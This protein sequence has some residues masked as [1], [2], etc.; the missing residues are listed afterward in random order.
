MESSNDIL[1]IVLVA[2]QLEVEVCLH[3]FTLVLDDPIIFILFV[4]VAVLALVELL[5]QTLFTCLELTHILLQSIDL[6]FLNFDGILQ[7]SD[8]LVLLSILFVKASDTLLQLLQFQVV[9]LTLLFEFVGGSSFRSVMVI[10]EFAHFQCEFLVA[11]LE[12]PN[13]LVAAPLQLIQIVALAGQNRFDQVQLTLQILNLTVQ[14]FLNISDFL[15]LDL[16]G[17]VLGFKF[18]LELCSILLEVDVPSFQLG[19]E[20]S[21]L[22]FQRQSNLVLL[23]DEVLQFDVLGIHHSFQLRNF[24]AEDLNLIGVGV[25]YQPYFRFAHA[26]KLVSQVGQLKFKYALVVSNLVLQS[27]IFTLHYQQRL[28]V[29]LFYL[30]IFVENLFD[31]LVLASDD[32]LEL[33]IFVVKALHFV[34]VLLL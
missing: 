24:M 5:S 31:F 13:L 6:S 14:Q 19:F 10:L 27:F 33:G 12:L 30:E 9:D 1:G 4:D 29:V 16:N 18:P 20:L 26:L 32:V 11:S 3:T 7:S 21:N 15:F 34:V 2:F 28:L 8:G 22:R 25:L 23:F 17:M